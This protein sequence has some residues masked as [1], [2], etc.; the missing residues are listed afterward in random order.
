MASKQSLQHRGIT[1]RR[2][3]LALCGLELLWAYGDSHSD[4]A[5]SSCGLGKGTLAVG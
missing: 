5:E 4:A 2:V 3:T 1:K